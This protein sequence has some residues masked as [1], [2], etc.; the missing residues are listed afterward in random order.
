MEESRDDA[1]VNGKAEVSEAAIRAESALTG[2]S[3][4]LPTKVYEEVC[5]EAH[6]RGTTC[7]ALIRAAVNVF[8]DGLTRRSPPM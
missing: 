3:V 5:R 8:L 7:S 1:A 4:R 6:T 2:I